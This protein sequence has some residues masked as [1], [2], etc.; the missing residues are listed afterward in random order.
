VY[1]YKDIRIEGGIPAIIDKETFKAVQIKLSE[2][3]RAPATAK[4]KIEYLLSTKLFCGHCNT[5]MIGESGTGRHGGSYYYYTCGSRKRGQGC[6]KKPL[7]KDFIERAVVEDVINLIKPES[8]NEIADMAIA[9][10]ERSISENT[11]IPRLKT[12]LAE[13]E[14]GIDNLMKVIEKGITSDSCIKRIAEL[15]DQKKNLEIRLAEEDQEIVYLEKSHI[16]SWLNQYCNGNIDDEDFRRRVINLFVHS[17]TVWDNP[18]GS[19]KI[20][21]VYNLTSA[22]S[23]TKSVSDLTPIAPP[24]RRAPPSAVLLFLVESRMGE[25][26]AVK[27][28]SGGEF[29]NGDRR[30]F[31]CST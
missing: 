30:K 25:S 3:K 21:S 19:Y 7:K 28:L 8:I 14:K 29:L 26:N 13:I 18:D 17:V 5:P 27:K 2:T 12:E 1:T 9:A 11:V 24:K 10:L 4:S 23:K 15:E 6:D 20:T 16:V 31:R 22:K